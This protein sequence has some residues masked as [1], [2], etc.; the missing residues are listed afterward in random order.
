MN[1]YTRIPILTIK[2]I[3]RIVTQRYYRREKLVISTNTN[4]DCT[5]VKMFT[6]HVY[7]TFRIQK[8]YFVWFLNKQTISQRIVFDYSP[9]DQFPV[10]P[11]AGF[12][13]IG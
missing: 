7:M 2:V 8:R 13:F 10:V 6:I 11:D 3:D 1:L 12:D 5:S 4:I 9:L